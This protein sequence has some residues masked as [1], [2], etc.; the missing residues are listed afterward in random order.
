TRPSIN[1]KTSTMGLDLRELYRSPSFEEV[2][3]D[4]SVVDTR[5]FCTFL[6][7]ERLRNI[8]IFSKKE[9]TLDYMKKMPG[10]RRSY[11]E[12]IWLS[13]LA[14]QDQPLDKTLQ[15]HLHNL[16]RKTIDAALGESITQYSGRLDEI[17]LALE[18][19]LIPGLN[20]FQ[21]RGIRVLGHLSPEV[22]HARSAT[23]SNEIN[24]C[25]KAHQEM[26][27]PVSWLTV[28]ATAF[29]PHIGEE[30]ADKIASMDRK[31]A[32]DVEL[33]KSLLQNTSIRKEKHKGTLTKLAE[34]RDALVRTYAEIVRNP[35]YLKTLPANT[36]RFLEENTNHLA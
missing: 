30:T 26:E 2:S 24:E 12:M 4:V 28:Y 19:E 20:S 15:Q 1:P 9:L 3:F 21:E 27:S 5:T 8:E 29:N 34:D 18:K 14:G 13:K 23:E 22:E 6:E 33:K 35:N 32:F 36:K 7:Y 25:Y 16:R 31:E 11:D 17:V 10:G